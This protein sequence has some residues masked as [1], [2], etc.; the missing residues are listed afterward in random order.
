MKNRRVFLLAVGAVIVLALAGFGLFAPTAQATL[1]PGSGCVP[2]PTPGTGTVLY[3][4]TATLPADAPANANGVC[5]NC[6]WTGGQNNTATL[7]ANAAGCVGVAA[8]AVGAGSSYVWADWG[9]N[10]CVAPGQTVAIR[11]RSGAGP[12][13]VNTVTW[14][15]A[16]GATFAGSGTVSPVETDYFP[17]SGAMVE[18]T[19]TTPPGS[20]RI[21]LRGPT[22]VEV[23]LAT[24][25]D[26]DS[27]GREQID[28]E[29]VQMQL[30]GTSALLGPVTMR[31]RDPAKQP[32]GSVGEMEERVNVQSNRFDLP[33]PQAPFCVEPVPPL[34]VGTLADSFFDVY[35]EVEAMG[36]KFH[37][38]TAEHMEAVISEKPPASGETYLSPQAIP[39]FDESENPSGIQVTWASHMPNPLG[40]GG[41]AEYPETAQTAASDSGSSDPP[42]A[43]LAGGLA[44]AAVALG[45]GAWYARRRW[46][47]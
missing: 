33:G 3:H 18:L 22:T 10:N 20:D 41:I 25:G 6:T 11:F 43:A 38:H 19:M 31:L 24:L 5:I 26:P 14:N 42:Y 7:L 1:P 45:A 36:Q 27:N 8:P 15:L 9:A 37:N 30:T 32:L 44:A 17:E 35:F 2:T 23:E 34:C 39:L 13:S 29:I 40:V 47:R 12:L 28:T 4:V 16:T 46:N 21:A